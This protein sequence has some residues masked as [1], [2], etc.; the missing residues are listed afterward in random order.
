MLAA[1]PYFLHAISLHCREQSCS[2]DPAFLASAGP[3]QDSFIHL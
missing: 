3:A 2:R 1:D